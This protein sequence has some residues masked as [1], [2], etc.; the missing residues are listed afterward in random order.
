VWLL[1]CSRHE[2]L[3]DAE[4]YKSLDTAKEV[5][6]IDSDW[7]AELRHGKAQMCWE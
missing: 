5:A 1:V 3:F 7:S 2:I 4:S 6:E